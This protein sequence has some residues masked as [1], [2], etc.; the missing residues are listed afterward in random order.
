MVLGITEA[1]SGSD[2]SF[3]LLEEKRIKLDEMML[4]M[5]E[6][7]RFVEKCTQAPPCMHSCI[8]KMCILCIFCESSHICHR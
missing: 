5:E 4:K 6:D 7:Y 1:L 2:E 3:L 8:S